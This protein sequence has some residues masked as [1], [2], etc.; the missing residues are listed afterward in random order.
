MCAVNV[1]GNVLPQNW[2][3]QVADAKHPVSIN[4]Y[5]NKNGVPL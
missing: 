1:V 4:Y 3:Q 2:I 5:L